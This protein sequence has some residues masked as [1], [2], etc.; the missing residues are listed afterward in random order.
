LDLIEEN[1][2]QR[3]PGRNGAF[4]RLKRRKTD[5]ERRSRQLERLFE[6]EGLEESAEEAELDDFVVEDDAESLPKRDVRSSRTALLK[7][8]SSGA[9]AE[10]YEVFGDGD[11][12]VY[13]LPLSQVRRSLK[14][15]TMTTPQGQ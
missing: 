4:K 3:L 10:F 13:A 1:T 7:G 12:Y 5:D 6:T 8:V 9:L 11:D 15:R 14:R 2:G